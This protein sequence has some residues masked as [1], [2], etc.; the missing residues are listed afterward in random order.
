MR[1][2]STVFV[3]RQ[4][5]RSLA[6]L[7]PLLS[8]VILVAVVAE[9]ASA[10]KPGAIKQPPAVNHQKAII[11]GGNQIYE[12][13]IEDDPASGSCGTWTATTGPLHPAGGLRFL[14]APPSV[15]P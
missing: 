2:P 12:I 14:S 9:E 13:F 15:Q 6:F 11:T 7:A 8:V 3:P 5:I 4:W 1:N 10:Q